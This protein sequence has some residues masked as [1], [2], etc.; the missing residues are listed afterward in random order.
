M[1][2][3]MPAAPEGFSEDISQ[4]AYPDFPR[5]GVGVLV[6]KQ[7]RCLL[8]IRGREPHKGKWTLPGGLVQVGE[9]LA[10][11]AARELYEECGIRARLISDPHLFEFIRDEGGETLYHFVIADFIAEYQDGDLRAGSDAAGAAWIEPEG[12][13]RMEL[14]PGTA[15]FIRRAYDRRSKPEPIR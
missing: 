3:S 7:E 5:L 10:Q 1:T 11:A 15:E 12:L 9:T 2:P 14:T 8:I 4:R 6:F 13:N